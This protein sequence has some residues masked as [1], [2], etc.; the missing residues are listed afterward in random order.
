MS[1]LRPG[2]L[3]YR[4]KGPDARSGVVAVGPGFL[5]VAPPTPIDTAHDKVLVLVDQAIAASGIDR[6]EAQK[7][8]AEADKDS[9]RG[10]VSSTARTGRSPS[11]ASGPGPP[12]RRRQS[13]PH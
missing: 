6:A 3:I 10:K 2:V 11:A 9:L 4:G 1:A 13:C 12:R 8:L 7:D 5:Q